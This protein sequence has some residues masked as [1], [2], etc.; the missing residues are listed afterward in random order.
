MASRLPP[1][2]GF[3]LLTLFAISGVLRLA[4]VAFFSRNVVEVRNV[5][6]V[7]VGDVLLGRRRA[8]GLRTSASWRRRPGP[9]MA[10]AQAAAERHGLKGP[11]IGTGGAL[12][13][14]PRTTSLKRD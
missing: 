13:K 1:L 11:M 2:F 10:S 14:A 9:V 6:W 3:K 8:V 5:P 4:V 12:A 7:A